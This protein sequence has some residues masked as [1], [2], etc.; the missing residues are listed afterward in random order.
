MEEPGNLEIE[1]KSVTGR[2]QGGNRFLG[3]AMEFEYS[4]TNRWTTSVYL[5]GQATG[6]QSALFTGY[7]WENRFRLFPH[8]HWINPVLYVEYA[9]VDAADKT[10]VE[11][12][13][14][15]DKEDLIQPNQIAHREKE[16]EIEARLILGSSF[17]GW[18]AAENLIAEKNLSHAPFEFGYTVGISRPL[19]LGSRTASCNLCAKSFQAGVEVYGG[20]GTANDFNF[21]GT[22]H[23]IAPV[24]SWTLTN[25]TTF[26]VS[27]GFGVSSASAPVLMRFG[28]SY[29]IDEFGQAV[30]GLFGSHRSA[31][32]TP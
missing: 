4:V 16:H 32:V 17:K 20:L 14:H 29:G 6:S 15:D 5:D 11:V 3:V 26:R 28:V 13:G 24:V 18:T 23:F 2:P 25:G 22:S 12:V 27:P 8:E 19:A 10:L 21:Q 1:T 31:P 30:R 7:R 9:N